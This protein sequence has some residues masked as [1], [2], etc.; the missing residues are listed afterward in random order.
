MSMRGVPLLGMERR[1]GAE[2]KSAARLL[3]FQRA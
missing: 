2:L 3:D 1:L